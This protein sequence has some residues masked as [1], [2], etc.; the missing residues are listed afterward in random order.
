MPGPLRLCTKKVFQIDVG[1]L[2]T[3]DPRVALRYR[4]GDRQDLRAL[5]GHP[6]YGHDSL[7]YLEGR[8]TAGDRLVMGEQEGEL[9]LTAWVMTGHMEL[10][11]LVIAL[12]SDY[13]YNYKIYTVEKFRRQGATLGLW[14][15]LRQTLPDHGIQHLM[16]TVIVDNTQS[17]HAHARAGFCPIGTFLELHLGDRSCYVLSGKLRRFL[18]EITSGRPRLDSAPA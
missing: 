4:F 8:L 7:P 13:A 1:S 6:D 16:S 15:F 12:P 14:K 5:A 3:I 9:V 18:R 11:D 10:G 2:P 17:L